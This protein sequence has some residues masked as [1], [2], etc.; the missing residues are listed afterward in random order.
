M[1]RNRPML[2]VI[3]WAIAGICYLPI[4]FC[5]WLL[6]IVARILLA[7]SY[8]GMLNAKMAFDVFKSLFHFNPSL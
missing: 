3:T 4:F 7:I 5:A 1:K 6:H 2:F 8:L